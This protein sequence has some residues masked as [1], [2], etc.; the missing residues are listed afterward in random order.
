MSG[1]KSVG[2]N[3]GIL[4]AQPGQITLGRGGLGTLRPAGAY[5]G[6]FLQFERPTDRISI[7]ADVMQELGI[8]PE[9][10]TDRFHAKTCK[11]CGMA[12]SPKDP[13]ECDEKEINGR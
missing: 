7:L 12:T 9:D 13:C 5:I 4:N 11:R 8:D 3:L 1:K 2:T 6:M 10:V